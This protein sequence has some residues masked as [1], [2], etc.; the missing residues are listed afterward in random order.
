MRLLEYHEDILDYL[1]SIG[2]SDPVIE[3]TGKHPKIRFPWKGKQ[4]QYTV[5]GTPSDSRH[6]AVKAIHDLRRILDN[7]PE[8]QP[9]IRERRN[10]ADMVQ[11]PHTY[12]S[13]TSGP[14]VF[15]VQSHVVGSP[16]PPLK[17]EKTVSI[18]GMSFYPTKPGVFR[19]SF[20][21]PKDLVGKHV[22]LG[23]RYLISRVSNDM[24]QLEPSAYGPTLRLNSSGQP[25]V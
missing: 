18:G 4:I 11:Q 3:Q 22:Q 23:K 20:K 1:A 5:P 2:V 19:L 25:L 24:W 17:E 7:P 6:G 14:K 10:L 15:P 21:V 12:P 8:V 13:A 16:V 9:E